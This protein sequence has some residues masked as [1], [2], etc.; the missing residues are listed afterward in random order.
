[1]RRYFSDKHTREPNVFS[2]SDDL[3]FFEIDITL[4]NKK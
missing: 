1:M 3:K 2:E 4:Q